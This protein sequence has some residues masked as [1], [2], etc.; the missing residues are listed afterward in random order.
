MSERGPRGKEMRVEGRL[1]LFEI[2]TSFLGELLSW[3]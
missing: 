3:L 2:G 1:E